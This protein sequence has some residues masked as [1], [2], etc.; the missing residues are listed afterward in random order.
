MWEFV[1][2]VSFL[3]I[4]KNIG[5]RAQGTDI[6]P[7]VFGS[8][9]NLRDSFKGAPETGHLLM[10]ALLGNLKGGSIARGLTSYKRKALGMDNPLYGGSVEQRGVCLSNG[11]FEM[12]LK[13]IWS[14]GVPLCGSSMKGIWRER[15]LAGEP[16]RYVGK[17]FETGIS[18]HMGSVWELGGRLIYR[19]N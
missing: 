1:R 11:D 2:R 3:G 19:G 18:F 9:G 12:W 7:L 16:E 4:R 17:S 6:T 8:P 15:S 5:W 14:C 10:G 13:G